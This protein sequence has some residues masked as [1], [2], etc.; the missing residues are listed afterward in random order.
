MLV[1]LV[2]FDSLPVGLML[3]GGLAGTGMCWKSKGVDMVDGTDSCD[4]GGG[5]CCCCLGCSKTVVGSACITEAD[6]GDGDS[7]FGA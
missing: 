1:M 4:A 3:L 2:R 7:G 6:D 5:S